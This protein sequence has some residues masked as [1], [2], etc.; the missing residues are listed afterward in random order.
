MA[1]L[2]VLIVGVVVGTF[3]G[4]VVM[5][6]LATAGTASELERDVVVA[7]DGTWTDRSPGPR[8][9]VPHALGGPVQDRQ[10][11]LQHARGGAP[12]RVHQSQRPAD[13]NSRTAHESSGQ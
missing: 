13:G 10:D 11:V 1:Y 5:A 9:A 3:V 6:A 2:M 12:T 7:K 8:E 4:V